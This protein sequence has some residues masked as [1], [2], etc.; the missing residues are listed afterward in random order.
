MLMFFFYRYHHL[1]YSTVSTKVPPVI[2][3]FATASL[4]VIIKGSGP[5]L[6]ISVPQSKSE[7]SEYGKHN[8]DKTQS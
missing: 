3:R 1:Q 6:R 5:Q 4:C 7:L 2:Q 8:D